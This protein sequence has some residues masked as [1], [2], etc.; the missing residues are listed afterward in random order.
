[1]ILRL[2]NSS[3]YRPACVLKLPAIFACTHIAHDIMV[4]YIT[5]ISEVPALQNIQN[6][7]RIRVNNNNEYTQRI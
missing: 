5:L 6:I 4:G 3:L 1:M 7:S 2:L